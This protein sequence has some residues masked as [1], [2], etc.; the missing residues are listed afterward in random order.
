MRE[1]VLIDLGRQ[2]PYL[3]RAMQAWP[4]DR[5]LAWLSVWGQVHEAHELERWST[6]DRRLYVFRSWV[7]LW[8]GFVL[9]GDGRMFI[10]GTG[11][12][13]WRDER[14]GRIASEVRGCTGTISK[15]G[16]RAGSV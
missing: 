2:M 1:F 16:W 11:I 10:P 3:P 6:P 15:G 8:T 14:A 9:T 13:A 5:L 12:A 4:G 7:G